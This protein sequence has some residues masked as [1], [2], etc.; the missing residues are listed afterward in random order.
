MSQPAGSWLGIFD[1]AVHVSV[2]PGAAGGGLAPLGDSG[3]ALFSIRRARAGRL[4][5]LGKPL[6][7]GPEGSIRTIPL[8]PTVTPVASLAPTA[9]RS[10]ELASTWS[11]P[12]R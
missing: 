10:R 5:N 12:T 2:G 3:T 6:R 7:H 11:T 1:A 4:V 8:R 9:I